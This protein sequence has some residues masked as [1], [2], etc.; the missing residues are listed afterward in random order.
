MISNEE[1]LR[2][3]KYFVNNGFYK[4]NN[5]GFGQE[6]LSK[7]ELCFVNSI[8]RKSKDSE[9][10]INEVEFNNLEHKEIQLYYDS[11]I[12][13]FL[14]SK[15]QIFDLNTQTGREFWQITQEALQYNQEFNYCFICS[16]LPI[17]NTK[18]TIKNPF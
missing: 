18:K 14:S 9:N 1:Y 17:N 16:S 7:M 4:S 13:N 15:G 8:L 6:N 2:L 5:I 3:V 11:M 10:I 12:L